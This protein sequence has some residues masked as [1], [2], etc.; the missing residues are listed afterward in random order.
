M[1]Q[2]VTTGSKLKARDHKPR[3]VAASEKASATKARPSS[4][5]PWVSARAFSAQR[6]E[7][8]SSEHPAVSAQA[9]SAQRGE[10]ASSENPAATSSAGRAA[11]ARSAKP[12]LEAMMQESISLLRHALKAVCEELRDAH[13]DNCLLEERHAALAARVAAVKLPCRKEASAS[14]SPSRRTPTVVTRTMSAADAASPSYSFP[15]QLSR[16]ASAPQ[17]S[18]ANNQQ[19]HQQHHTNSCYAERSATSI[20][21]TNFS[22]TARYTV[23][24]SPTRST[25]STSPPTGSPP[26]ASPVRPGALVASPVRPGALVASP[27]RPGAL[28]A[29][30]VRPGALVTASPASAA[31]SPASAMTPSASTTAVT[32]PVPA[33][34]SPTSSSAGMPPAPSPAETLLAPATAPAPA[35]EAAADARCNVQGAGSKAGKA[36]DK[37]CSISSDK[38]DGRLTLRLSRKLLRHLSDYGKKSRTLSSLTARSRTCSAD[39][40]SG[41]DS[42]SEVFEANTPEQVMEMQDVL[43][44]LSYRFERTRSRVTSDELPPDEPRKETTEER[45]RSPHRL[46]PGLA[47]EGARPRRLSIFQ[48]S[49]R[50]SSG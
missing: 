2:P 39:T 5:A 19:H 47:Q 40:E 27:V 6:R 26:V 38:S 36:S 17:P 14:L 22:P 31:I 44:Q 50:S 24:S 41:C 20:I 32:P 7:L 45:R 29:S 43:L 21:S 42:G 25:S 10:L 35:Q 11:E 13:R 48:D 12:D 49:R 1:E 37:R 18:Q 34:K 23:T 33:T 3:G 4:E 16:Q 8:A 15:S 30:P 9:D 28:V 46:A